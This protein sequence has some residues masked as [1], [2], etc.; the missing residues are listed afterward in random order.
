MEGKIPRHIAII[1]DGNGRWAERKG[2]PR[3]EGH[4]KGIETAKDIVLVARRLGV[5]YLTLYTFS[6]ENWN[7][8]PEEVEMLM[9]FLE[10]H[11]RE[12]AKTLMENQIRLKVIGR[13]ENL[14]EGVRRVIEEVEGLTEENDAM[15]LQLA[16][17]YGG[18]QELVDAAKK[19]AGLVK[20][21]ELE[22][23]DIDEKLF[24]GALYTAGVPEP[25][26]LI[27]TSGEKRIS[28]F[29]LWQIAYTELYITE[30][31]WPDFT[32]DDLLLAIKDFKM[33][34]RRFGLTREQ[35]LGI[36]G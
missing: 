4:R 13:R 33:R 1:M 14:P 22:P 19:I 36:V 6:L 28:N 26:L 23:E 20:R 7:R 27:R 18:R 8:P 10:I 17:S 11:L 30:T 3:I 21:G 9:T 5:E 29:L 15:V 32:E 31:L 2:L 35:A 16:I 25:D 12:E 34:E 24:E